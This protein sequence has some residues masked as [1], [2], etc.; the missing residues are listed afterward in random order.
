M[1][2]APAYVIAN[3][4]VHDKDEYR[5]YE[6]GFFPDIKSSS[7]RIFYLRRQ[8]SDLRGRRAQGRSNGYLQ[9]SE[10]NRCQVMV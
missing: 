9:I 6:K 5:K 4:I 8:A 1:S 7:R 10:R 3:F 2:D